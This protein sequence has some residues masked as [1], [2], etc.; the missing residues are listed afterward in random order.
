MQI[1][2]KIVYRYLARQRKLPNK[3][4]GYTQ[5]FKIGGQ[6]F[7]MRTGEYADGSLG[8]IFLTANREGATMRALLNIIAVAVSLGLQ[9]G[10]PLEEFVDAFTFTRFEPAGP[11]IDHDNLKMCTSFMDAFFR[12]LAFNYLGRVDLAQIRPEE[13]CNRWPMRTT[14][15]PRKQTATGASASHRAQIVGRSQSL[16]GRLRNGHA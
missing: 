10:V 4:G 11:V 16:R 13:S 7:Y 9:H 12:D 14:S 5:K 3:R 2:E 15:S 1:A 8:E 6:K